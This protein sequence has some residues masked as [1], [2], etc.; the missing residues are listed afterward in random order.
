MDS[1]ETG[2]FEPIYPIK[3][4]LLCRQQPFILP[5]SE[6][7]TFFSEGHVTASPDVVGLQE[8][9]HTLQDLFFTSVTASGTIAILKSQIRK[10]EV[11]SV[12]HEEL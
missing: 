1:D 10:G 7:V 12:S 2:D 9:A 8:I 4:I 5:L 6:K 11:Q 3:S